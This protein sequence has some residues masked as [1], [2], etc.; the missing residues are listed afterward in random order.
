MF[1]REIRSVAHIKRWSI[2]KTHR[3]QSVAEHTYNVAMYANDILS[4]LDLSPIFHVAVLQQA[5]WHDVDEIF[6]GDIPGP[7]KR[8]LTHGKSQYKEVLGKWM[9][10]IFG[11][12]RH[13]RTGAGLS[14]LQQNIATAILKVADELDAA[15]EMAAEFGM[16]NTNAR[17]LIEQRQKAM[18]DHFDVLVSVASID[19]Q[20]AGKLR[21]MLVTAIV[22]AYEPS[23]APTV[24]GE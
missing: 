9:D 24:F 20:R 2:V 11:H 8:A 16:G 10:K 23:R 13:N 14:D 12:F 19:S 1:E 3:D 21:A 5:L 18:L 15:C 6:T 22:S 4:Y 7:A 17:P